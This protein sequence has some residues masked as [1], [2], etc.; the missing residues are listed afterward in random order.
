MAM[1]YAGYDVVVYEKTRK[2]L[3]LGD[4][5]GVGANALRLL[6]RWGCREKLVAIGNKR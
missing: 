6:T 4:S 5:L 2:F 1:R 3:R